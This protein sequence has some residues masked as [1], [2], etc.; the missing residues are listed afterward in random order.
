[1]TN[2]SDIAAECNLETEYTCNN[3]LCVDAGLVCDGKPDCQ[4][5]TDEIGCFDT[6]VVTDSSSNSVNNNG[7]NNATCMLGRFMSKCTNPFVNCSFFQK[8]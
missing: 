2:I 4:D 6:N 1:M 5:L 8:I 7:N 3:G